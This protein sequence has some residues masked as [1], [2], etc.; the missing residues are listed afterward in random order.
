MQRAHRICPSRPSPQL[1]G[2]QAP[3]AGRSGGAETGEG[4]V[5]PGLAVIGRALLKRCSPRRRG[6]RRRPQVDASASA[7]FPSKKD[8]ARPSPSTSSLVERVSGRAWISTVSRQGRRPC[9]LREGTSITSHWKG[10]R[11]ARQSHL[12]THI[13]QTSA[14]AG[15][16]KRERGWRGCRGRA[17]PQ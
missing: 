11:S 14:R 8:P 2:L 17:R 10:R 12:G 13:E 7:V 1:D 9:A 15:C 3:K 16:A 6:K 4:G 5:S